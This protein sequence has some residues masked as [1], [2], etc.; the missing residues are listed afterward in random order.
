[1]VGKEKV[2]KCQYCKKEVKTLQQNKTYCSA[3]CRIKYH[4]VIRFSKTEL[5]KHDE[6]DQSIWKEYNGEV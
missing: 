3:R 2:F 6:Y 1:M 5:F 4:Q